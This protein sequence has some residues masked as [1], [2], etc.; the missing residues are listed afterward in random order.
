MIIQS[1]FGK[2]SV[3]YDSNHT[4][5]SIAPINAGH[6]KSS[7][8][9]SQN[10]TRSGGAGDKNVKSVSSSNYFKNDPEPPKQTDAERLQKLAGKSAV[11]SSDLWDDHHTPAYQ[12]NPR[13]MNNGMPNIFQKVLAPFFNFYQRL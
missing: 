6:T 2:F 9:S 7:G 5:N 8:K 1:I 4:Y 12:A 3:S 10:I 11:S 13:M